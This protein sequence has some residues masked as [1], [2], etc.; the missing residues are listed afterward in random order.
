[1]A[2]ACFVTYTCAAM[3]SWIRYP[4]FRGCFVSSCVFSTLPSCGLNTLCLTHF[5]SVSLFFRSV[6]QVLLLWSCKK[7]GPVLAASG[8][9]SDYFLAYA[10]Y[11]AL[12]SLHGFLCRYAYGNIY[13]LARSVMARSNITLH[14]H[15]VQLGTVI[16]LFVPLFSHLLLGPM[17]IIHFPLLLCAHL[18]LLLLVVFPFGLPLH[19]D[20]DCRGGDVARL[21]LV[22]HIVLL[23]YFICFGQLLFYKAPHILYF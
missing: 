5:L 23:S 21:H 7:S 12:H 17:M 16:A 13:L 10:S 3:V 4:A 22:G 18:P 6:R 8:S 14:A 20:A 9:R 1:M 19:S 2:C 15:F 11:L